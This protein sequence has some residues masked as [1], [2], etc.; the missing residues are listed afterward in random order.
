MR[1]TVTWGIFGA[2][3]AAVAILGYQYHRASGR[4]AILTEEN[5]RLRAEV[6][7]VV[8]VHQQ[9]REKLRA[10]IRGLQTALAKAQ[11]EGV[12]FQ[13]ALA[14]TRQDAQRLEKTLRGLQSEKGKL[15]GQV[16][17]L[18]AEKEAWGERLAKMEKELQTWQG[19]AR[20][21]T[22]EQEKLKTELQARERELEQATLLTAERS[23]EIQ[24]L[25][26]TLREREEHIALLKRRVAELE[27]RPGP[28][29][30]GAMGFRFRITP[31]E[32]ATLLE[33]RSVFFTRKETDW[34]EVEMTF[35]GSAGDL[36]ISS[37]QETTLL[38]FQEQL[39]FISGTWTAEPRK[40]YNELVEW[41]RL[42]YGRPVEYKVQ[43]SIWSLGDVSIELTIDEKKAA[44]I[45]YIFR[46]LADASIKAQRL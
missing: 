25:T 33:S 37:P 34:G 39:Y 4:I 45:A 31:G 43:R 3:C 26:E 40:I 14:A 6:E 35:S 30:L 27:A 28:Q 7:G 36:P 11:Q 12:K 32:V 20:R 23:A 21:L 46:P 5:T 2:A 16:K 22:E 9:D 10:E 44:H 24:Q 18:R 38:F 8:G 42:K 17:T 19:S 41:L 1:N 13:E 29:I 15:E